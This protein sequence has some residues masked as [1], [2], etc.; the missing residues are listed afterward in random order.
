MTSAAPTASGTSP[1]PR[2]EA[3]RAARSFLFVPGDR[4]ERFD[5]AA[6]AGA[7]LVIIDLEDAVGAEHKISAREAAVAW[8]R[9][10]GTACVRVNA[11]D[12][13]EHE[14]DLA[15][16]A[17]AD[18]LVAVVLPKAAG[19]DAASAVARRSGAPVVALVESAAGVLRAAQI[20]AAEGVVRLAFG[21]LDYAVDLGADNG[22]TAMLH[23]RSTLVLASRAAGLPGPVDGVTVALDD[24]A[25]LAGDL[26]HGRE[27]GMTGKLLIHPRQ[28]QAT[29]AAYRPSQEEVAWAEKVLTAVRDTSGGAVRV[30]GAMVDAP[31]IA[32]AEDVLRRKEELT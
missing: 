16:L 30:D 15:A 31:V 24:P 20:A 23:A 25:V 8:L 5:K 27:L 18:G 3:V 17:G 9:G 26:G 2:V 1:D 21:H 22:R 10:G 7:D 14:A 4:P 12:S 28:V 6:A 13:T 29:H 19:A 11:A 32:R